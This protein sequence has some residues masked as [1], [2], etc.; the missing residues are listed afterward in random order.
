MFGLQVR[1][2][3]VLYAAASNLPEMS[4]KDPSFCGLGGNEHRRSSLLVNLPDEVYC[5]S[6]TLPMTGF[7]RLSTYRCNSILSGLN[8]FKVSIN[9]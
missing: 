1:E 6:I 2:L 7:K 9:V 5:T 3:E 8:V 4:E